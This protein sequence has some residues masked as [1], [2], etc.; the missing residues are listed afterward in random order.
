MGMEGKFYCEL[1]ALRILQNT[2]ASAIIKTQERKVHANE[3]LS[4]DP[5]QR[6]RER[7]SSGQK[8]T[9]AQDAYI[10]MISMHHDHKKVSPLQ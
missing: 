7:K 9:K 8:Q 10:S 2:K 4:A 1:C 5:L 6:Q 3:E